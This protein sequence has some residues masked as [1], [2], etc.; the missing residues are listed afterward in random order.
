M[1]TLEISPV[2]TTQI[3]TWTSNDPVLSQ[4]KEL[5]LQGWVDTADEQLQ[6]YQRRK[7][8]LNIHTGCILLEI[9]VVVP[10]AGCQK[11]MEQLHQGHP[12]I[13]RVKGPA[14]GFVWWPGMDLDLENTVKLCPNCQVNQ[15]APPVAPL[16]P[17]EWPQRP[18]TRLHL[19]YAGPFFGKMFLV[20]VDAYSKW[21]DAQVVSAATS[22]IT[23]EH[24]QTLF[25]MHGIP[26][27]VVSDIGTPFTSAEFAEFTTKNGIH[28]VK[29]SPYHPSSNRLAERTVRTL[30]EGL[31]KI[32]T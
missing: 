15:K 32:G 23:N 29:V 2:N 19:D 3:R 24:L 14:R 31:R 4:V 13:T 26:T 1:D 12:G 8:E 10:P 16:H 25:A 30:K 21:I 7:D 22:Y 20:T 17:W 5:V 6:L 28:H 18:W 11:M 9:R 27:A